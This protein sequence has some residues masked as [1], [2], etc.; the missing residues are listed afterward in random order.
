MGVVSYSPSVSGLSYFGFRGG[1][2][3][4]EYRY[5]S[6]VQLVPDGLKNE[7]RRRQRL[8]RVKSLGSTTGYVC[9]VCEYRGPFLAVDDHPRR[10]AAVCP[11]C[12][13]QERHRL[14]SLVI[15]QLLEKNDVSRGAVLHFAPEHAIGDKLSAYFQ[16]YETAD[17]FDQ[18]QTHVADI[19][20][21]QFA[22]ESY[23]CVYASHVLEHVADDE[24]AV[25]EIHRILRPGGVAILPVPI[26][27]DQTVEYP[28]PSPTE[29]YHVRAPGLDYFDRYRAIFS[30]VEVH[31]S[32]D[33]DTQFQLCA[34]EDR[35]V[36]PTETAPWR[37]AQQ[38]ERHDDYVPV[39]RKAE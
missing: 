17:L 22:D 28:E 19:S 27:C 12:G 31:S 34:I 10:D 29:F 36:F 39:C 9:P 3:T 15:D 18:N 16:R 4:M 26:V 13:S 20:N 1:I 7:I 24:Q 38:G 11:D 5:Q 37:K 35:T 30:S 33:F 8:M 6:L 25:R 2:S 14:Q 21:M 23:D 32:E